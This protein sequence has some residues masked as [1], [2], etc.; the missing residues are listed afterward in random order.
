M[1]YIYIEFPFF[2]LIQTG[3]ESTPAEAYRRAPPHMRRVPT[4]IPTEKHTHRSYANT[5]GCKKCRSFHEMTMEK[6]EINKSGEKKKLPTSR[7]FSKKHRRTL[8]IVMNKQS[9]LG[10]TSKIMVC[11]FDG[12][13]I[14]CFF[15]TLP[16]RRLHSNHFGLP[17]STYSPPG[18]AVLRRSKQMFSQ[19]HAFI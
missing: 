7:G 2:S 11:G 19:P 15:Q 4:T 6:I 3:I 1:I 18:A 17:L 12:I 16:L 13:S 14:L 8:T 5:R 9:P 10:E